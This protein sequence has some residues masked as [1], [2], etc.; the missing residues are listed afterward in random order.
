MPTNLTGEGS[1]AFDASNLCQSC[2]ICCDGTIF[3]Y[4]KTYPEEIEK[5]KKLGL[6]VYKNKEGFYSFDLGCPKYKNGCCSVYLDRPQKC[7]SFSCKL[8]HDVMNGTVKYADSLKIVGLVKKHTQW[9]RDEI[10]VKGTENKKELNYR[11]M[12]FDYLMAAKAKNEKS[13]LT[14]TDVFRIKRIFEQI[15]LIDRFF[16]ESSLLRKYASLI[17]SIKA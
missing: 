5:T 10:L 4:V 2:G 15:K 9:V 13:E 1:S 3:S 7:E 8:H 14:P 17:Q 16:E 12:L 6:S 11:V